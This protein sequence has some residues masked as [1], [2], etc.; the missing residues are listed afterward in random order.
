VVRLVITPADDTAVPP[1]PAVMESDTEL[2]RRV[3]LSLDGYST[4]GSRAGYIYHA[5]SASGDVLDA[6]AISPAPGHVTVYVL[7]RGGSGAASPDLLATVAAAVNA[8]HARP[9]TDQVTVL[10][11]AIVNYNIAAT[12]IVPNGPDGET[13]QAAALQACTALVADIHRIGADVN[14]SAIYRALHQVGALRIDLTQPAAN[15]P[16][17]SGQ[18]AYCTGIV[19]GISVE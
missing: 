14:L 18:A 10:S 1:I 2:R 4:A 16:I 7:A 8:E 19:L 5:L 17:G 15:I 12:I 11:A 9:I 6:D 3:L 13:I